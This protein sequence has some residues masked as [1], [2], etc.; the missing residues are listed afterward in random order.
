MGNWGYDVHLDPP[1]HPVM[2]E[3]QRCEGQ[4]YNG[5]CSDACFINRSGTAT[6]V[7]RRSRTIQCL[8]LHHCYFCDGFGEVEVTREMAREMKNNERSDR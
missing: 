5:P 3:C 8:E 6:G 7:V 4:G 2:V 1:G